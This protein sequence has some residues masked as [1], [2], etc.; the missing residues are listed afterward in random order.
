MVSQ[1]NLFSDIFICFHIRI[2]NVNKKRNK[3]IWFW[4]FPEWI[5]EIGNFSLFSYFQT[6]EVR[7]LIQIQIAQFYS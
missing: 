5:S 1:W 2:A 6:L 7:P 3:K 4:D